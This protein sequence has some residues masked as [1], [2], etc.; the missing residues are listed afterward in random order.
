MKAVALCVATS[1]QNYNING[2][3]GTCPKINHVKT[4]AYVVGGEISYTIIMFTEKGMVG[5]TFRYYFLCL[6]NIDLP[7]VNRLVDFGT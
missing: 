2:S 3:V 5:E 4:K 7:L 6:Q 1:T